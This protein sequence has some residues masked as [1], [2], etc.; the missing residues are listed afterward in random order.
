MLLVNLHVILMVCMV[1]TVVLGALLRLYVSIVCCYVCLVNFWLWLF[2]CVGL[3]RRF[4]CCL[5]MCL[6]C[7]GGCLLLFVVLLLIPVCF[8]GLIC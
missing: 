2:I 6:L 7:V 8:R 5:R 3:G 4:G 1:L